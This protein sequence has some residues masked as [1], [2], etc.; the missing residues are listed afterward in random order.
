MLIV[1]FLPMLLTQLGAIEEWAM[2]PTMAVAPADLSGTRAV[3]TGGCGSLGFHLATMLAQGGAGVV[4]GCHGVESSLS[5]EAGIESRI[6][7]MGLLRHEND[8]EEDI[9]GRGWIEVW[10][11]QL[12]SF[13][14]VR[15]FGSRVAELGAVNLLV[16]S[17]ATKSA[18]TK[19]EDGFELSLQV[20]YLSPF[21]LT[22]LL[23]P[24]LQK[25]DSSRV[26]LLTCDAGL[27]QADWLPWPLSRTRPELLPRIS[28]SSLEPYME[29]QGPRCNQ[30][31][32]Y[33]S[34][35]L[36]LVLHASEL[37]RR[38]GLGQSPRSTAHSVNPGAMLSPLHAHAPP[39]APPGM[40]STMM[41]FLPP[42]WIMKKIY[43]FVFT[44]LGNAMLRD[45]TDGA[46]AVFHVATAP[47]LS[48][49]QAGGG[50]FSDA[51]GP[52]IDCGKLA[53]KCGRL[54]AADLP[55]AASD[56]QLAKQLWTRTESAL[57][58]RPPVS[59]EE[60]DESW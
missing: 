11:L 53:A 42:V 56:Q 22:Q 57:A 20:N 34:S 13:A 18:C 15:E 30:G 14:S 50:L 46:K 25:A 12:E 35:K 1:T 5:A 17:A 45:P 38:L 51:A 16:H 37:D 6:G 3:I 10:P 9:N 40:R 39:P 48:T 36:A 59:R 23:L 29:G 60:D 32:E 54:K 44:R 55:P 24:A 8:D 33:A 31:L 28:L 19:T 21:L 26:V 58:Q 41:G 27:T 2:R 43:G 49:S 7:E 47:A 52:F 4:L